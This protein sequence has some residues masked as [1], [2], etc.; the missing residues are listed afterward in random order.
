MD[1]VSV[2]VDL[3]AMKLSQMDFQISRSLANASRLDDSWRNVCL[4]SRVA[5]FIRPCSQHQ[6]RALR[7]YR[8]QQRA[9]SSQQRSLHRP[10]M[11]SY[12][13]ATLEIA[14]DDEEMIDE[15]TTAATSTISPVSPL[16]SLLSSKPFTF[17]DPHY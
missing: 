7:V 4:S 2:H 1:G 12:V 13:V 6:H 11:Q 14:P 16:A 10:P 9:V 17:S 15:R 8:T 5:S 3:N